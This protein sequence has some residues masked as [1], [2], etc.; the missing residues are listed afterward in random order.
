[1][2]NLPV[3]ALPEALQKQIRSLA[4][5]SEKT[6]RLAPDLLEIMYREKWFRLFVPKRFGGLALSLPDAVRLEENLS[7]ADGSLGWTVTLCAGAGWF[8][9]F[10][11]ETV[12]QKFFTERDMCIAGSGAPSGTAEIT[13]GGY[14]IDGSWKYA[15][16]AL[17]A[18]AFTANCLLEKNGRPLTNEHGKPLIRSFIFKAEEIVIDKSWA[19]MGMIAT[20]SHTFHATHLLVPEERCFLIAPQNATL[21]EAVYQYPFLSLA[22]V[23]L[24]ANS[25]G[26]CLHFLEL[27][28]EILNEKAK[29]QNERQ[30]AVFENALTNAQQTISEYRNRFYDVL[31]ASWNTCAAGKTL[32]EKQLQEI[33]ST[34]RVLA[35][36]CRHTMDE[37]YP[38]CGLA[39][40]QTNTEINRVWRD[41]HTA[42]Q[43]ALLLYEA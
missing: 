30:N 6:G 41:V 8:A 42:S 7:R 20:G 10:L 22:K 27:C 16:G 39:A 43:H 17:H 13:D 37:L 32:T 9:G 25:L 15:T 18:T 1:M 24:A 2:M 36:T 26:M 28:S 35:N 33:S 38:Y 12:L 19:S 40:A 3:Y 4:A 34:S 29:R 23:T 5:S 21:D 14:I 31:D 11:P